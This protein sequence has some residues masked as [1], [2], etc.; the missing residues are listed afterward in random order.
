MPEGAKDMSKTHRIVF[1]VLLI[2]L[3]F[4]C[5]NVIAAEQ[6]PS[7]AVTSVVLI[8]TK[9]EYVDEKNIQADMFTALSS[10]AMQLA[11][12][13][14]LD[15]RSALPTTVKDDQV[16]KLMAFP[17]LIGRTDRI[18]RDMKSDG[19]LIADLEMFGKAGTRY[20]ISV[21]LTLYDFRTGS[22]QVLD[23]GTVDYKGVQEKQA[24]LTSSADEVIKYMQR[25]VP[26]MLATTTQASPDEMVVVNKQSSRFHAA[27]CHHL[28]GVSVQQEKMSREQALAAGYQACSICY[29]ESRRGIDP[30]SIEAVLGAETAGF[31]EYYYRRS[32]DPADYERITRIG[33]AIAAA[34]HFTRRD[35]VFTALKTEEVNAIAAPGGYVYVTTGMLKAVESDD[36]LACVLGHEMAHVEREHGV[37]EYRRAQN[38]ALLGVLVSVVTG[39]DLTALTDFVQ[40]IV[41]RG[42]DRKLEAE[43]DR[44]GYNYVRH[45]NYD[46]E[47]DFTLLG[48]LKDMEDQSNWK[49]AGWMRTHPKSDDRIKYIT[50]YKATMAKSNADLTQME[51]VDAGMASAIRGNEMQYMDSMA[52]LKAYVDT[53][54]SLP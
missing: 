28:P 34:N 31:I 53:V 20:Y 24:F 46:A 18:R 19:V 39:V 3:S 12:V 43:A 49:V 14:V 42:Y 2:A 16:K 37:K 50:E 21:D 30:D 48:K 25:V 11:K 13:R 6:S 51:Q 33:N 17:E 9:S 47:A 41:L 7:K 38:S 32:N 35:Y 1:A 45:T 52:Q 5:T 44:Y 8:C 27:D 36:E 22:T 23:I 29:P 10:R 54:K 4:T 40:E 26:G 15:L